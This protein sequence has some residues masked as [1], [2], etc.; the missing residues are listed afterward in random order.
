[1]STHKHL[2]GTSQLTREW[3]ESEL[4]PLCDELRALIACS[5]SAHGRMKIRALEPSL[6]DILSRS[7][8][9]GVFFGLTYGNGKIAPAANTPEKETLSE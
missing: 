6:A 3:M 2:T 5:S 9:G 4:F 8:E 7:P 1:M